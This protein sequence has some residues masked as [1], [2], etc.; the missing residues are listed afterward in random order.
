MENK[1]LYKDGVCESILPGKRNLTIYGCIKP[2]GHRGP[3]VNGKNIG[4]LNQWKI[5]RGESK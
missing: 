5:S 1:D 4:W 3:H 2:K